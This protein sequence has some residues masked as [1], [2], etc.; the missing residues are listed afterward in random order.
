MQFLELLEADKRA[1]AAGGFDLFQLDLVD[2]LGAAGGLL[3][4]GGV[5]REA[6]DEGLQLGDL[7]FLLG[8]VR[9]QTLARLG[10]GGHVLVVVA[11]EQAQLAVIQVG[12]V[13]ADRVQEVTVVGNDDH[14]AGTRLEYVFQ[15]ADGVDIQVVGRFVQQQH[16]RIGEQRLGQQHTQLPAGGD[17]AHRAEVLFQRNAETEQQ[18]TGAGFGGVAVHF[19]ELAFQF[20]DF[21]PVFFAHFRQ[22]VDAV[23]LGLDLPQLLV[24]HDHGVDHAELF[25]GKLVLAQLTQTHVLF[26]HDLAAGGLQLAAKDLHEGRLAAAVGTD[27]AVAVAVAEFDGDVFE[28]RLGAKLHGDVGGGDHGKS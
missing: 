28:Q 2:L 7:R 26:E 13:S 11:G 6:A 9:Q 16:I 24:T 10:S 22:R 14:G 1:D 17:F 18:F 19:R 21:H 15:P 20:A 4:L 8:V 12:H 5:G 25:V 27:Q 23:A 3:G